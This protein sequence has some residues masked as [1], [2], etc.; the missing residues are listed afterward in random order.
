MDERIRQRAY[1]I[2]EREGRPHG[3]EAEHWRKAA[4]EL[5]EP[6]PPPAETQDVPATRVRAPAKL[7]DSTATDSP[8]QASPEAGASVAP[9]VDA[10]ADPLGLGQSAA[11][12]A[13]R[14]RN[15]A[16]RGNKSR[17]PSNGSSPSD[18]APPRTPD[19]TR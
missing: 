14:K 19:R 17:A 9:K 16:P 11:K 12:P 3:R 4:E 10:Q 1:E 6:P 7:D 2:W 15:A 13:P 8:S 5:A 18:T